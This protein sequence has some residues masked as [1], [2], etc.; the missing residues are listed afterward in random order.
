MNDLFDTSALLAQPS[1]IS[2]PPITSARA[3]PSVRR[4]AARSWHRQMLL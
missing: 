1:R 2:S 3:L 4:P